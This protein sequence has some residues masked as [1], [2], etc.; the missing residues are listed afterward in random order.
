MKIIDNYKIAKDKKLADNLYQELL[1]SFFRD[2]EMK[3]RGNYD[4][5]TTTGDIMV[6]SDKVNY[7]VTEL[8]KQKAYDHNAKVQVETLD[9]SVIFHL[10]GLIENNNSVYPLPII[11]DG[12][13]IENTLFQ[14]NKNEKWLLDELNKSNYQLDEIFYGFY[15]K[16]NL[17][18]IKKDTIK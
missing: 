7:R 1:D 13:I 16:N 8:V 11:I 10:T 9:N 4:I 5:L 2:Y 3:M 14:I 6:S 18:L 15:R 17:F 12:R